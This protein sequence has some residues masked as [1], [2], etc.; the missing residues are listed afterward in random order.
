MTAKEFVRKVVAGQWPIL[1]VGLIF[2]AAF[3]L[4]VAGYWRRGALFIGI[5]VG[6]AAALR[7]ALT[8][9]RAGLLVVRSRTIDF[10]T[11]ATA[12]AAVLYIAWTIDPLG[13]S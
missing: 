9:D 3:A 1:V 2:V 5:G 8:D 11:T 4:V 7:L 13:T 6:A 12:S 10:A